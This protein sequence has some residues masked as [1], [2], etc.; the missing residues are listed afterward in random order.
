MRINFCDGWMFFMLALFDDLEK[1]T[2]TPQNR[3]ERIQSDSKNHAFGFSSVP[4]FWL[5]I[6][7]SDA[8]MLFMGINWDATSMQQ[9]KNPLRAQFYH[10]FLLSTFIILSLFSTSTWRVFIS[11]TN[12]SSRSLKTSFTFSN[13]FLF[14]TPWSSTS[15]VSSRVAIFSS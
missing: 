5:K 14:S 6:E 13:C 3:F 15:I 12:S 8:D 4:F 9:I 1:N 11:S 2:L 10:P 7:V